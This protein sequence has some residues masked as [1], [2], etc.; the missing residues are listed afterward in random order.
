M[1]S[2]LEDGLTPKASNGMDIA[3]SNTKR[4]TEINLGDGYERERNVLHDSTTLVF[5]VYLRSS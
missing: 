2:M 5:N 4:K 1:Q 3:R